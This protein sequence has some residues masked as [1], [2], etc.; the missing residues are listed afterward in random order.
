MAEVGGSKFAEPSREIDVIQIVDVL[1]VGGGPAG[2][3]AAVASAR[4]GARTML[5]EMG[6]AL[7]GTWTLGMQTHAT[8]FH[9][10]E[11]MI[12][13]GIAREIV[14]RLVAEGE[15]EDPEAKLRSHPGAFWVC[16]NHEMMKCVLDD[17][18]VEAGADTLLHTL[19]VGA[20]VE[21][22]CVKGIV[23]ESK[24]GRR[25]IRAEVVIDC[26]GDADVAFFSNAPTVKGRAEDGRCQPVTTTFLLGNV[27]RERALKFV[28][29]EQDR[30]RKLED[31]ARERGDLTVPQKMRIGAGT[32]WPDVTYHNYTR[33]L[34]VD[35]T[36]AEDLTRAEIEG[37]R[38]VL[39]TVTFLRRHV[40]GYEKSRLIAMASRV[41]LRE[42]RR[43]VGAYTL[44]SDDVLSARKFPDGVARHAYYIDVHNPDGFGLEGR[45][46]RDLRPPA[47][48]Y[49]EIP[50]GCLVPREREQLLVA[51]RCISADRE[52]LGSTRT[53]V[54]CAALGEAAGLA[55]A[56]AVREKKR[57]REVDGTK[58]KAM[59]PKLA[60]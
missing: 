37:R 31:E 35:S 7:G 20:I 50:Y 57:V 46:H 58:L 36:R 44:T 11:K 41:G 29:D 55:A 45:A 21:E 40:P 49:Y 19:C 27:D 38:Q 2:V 30:L 54:C 16:F 60:S 6:G 1:V 25:A 34:H 4:A 56:L 9:D 15:T 8:F 10:G 53:T 26:T 3:P 33:I 23:T 47:G 43:M 13:G 14:E 52:A 39:E 24:S 17:M 32:L 48:D 28:L 22:G 12:V 18:V 42:S 51:G 5:V 59:L